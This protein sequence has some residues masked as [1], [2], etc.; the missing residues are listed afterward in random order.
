MD[1]KMIEASK[2]KEQEK[3]DLINSFKKF[4]M[5]YRFTEKIPE[6]S[7]EQEEELVVV[8]PNRLVSFIESDVEFN[9]QTFTEK[10]ALHLNE[11]V[12]A[13]QK[14]D[15][16]DNEAAIVSLI[17][18]LEPEKELWV[19]IIEQMIRNVTVN[20]HISKIFYFFWTIWASQSINVMEKLDALDLEIFVRMC[21]F[22]QKPLFQSKPEFRVDLSLGFT[23]TKDCKIKL[24]KIMSLVVNPKEVEEYKKFNYYNLTGPFL[25]GE[26]ETIMAREH[27]AKEKNE[28][29]EAIKRID[30]NEKGFLC[31][32]ISHN[33]PICA[34]LFTLMASG[35]IKLF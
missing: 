9:I 17:K 15:I 6:L 24:H 21:E 18:Q 3:L 20:R 26:Q 19:E 31:P 7:E 14:I 29:I 32:E 13:I 2:K 30:N 25:Y 35:N 27:T 4:Q 11:P 12:I 10:I 22:L 34:I 5:E 1:E 16:E 8:P 33:D 28:L 23:L